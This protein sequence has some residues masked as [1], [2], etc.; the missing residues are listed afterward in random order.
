[1]SLSTP[2]LGYT[3]SKSRLID[4]GM[5][6]VKKWRNSKGLG[7]LML[8]DGPNIRKSELYQLSK[9]IGLEWFKFVLLVSSSQDDYVPFDSAR[10]EIGPRTIRDKLAGIYEEMAS[11][12]VGRMSATSLMRVDVNYVFDKKNFDYFIGRSAHIQMLDNKK[13]I[14]TLIFH[15]WDVFK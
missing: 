7:Q 8:H 15:F 1:M 6:F 9:A 5:W 10:I 4:A 11:N 3:P 14:K 13:L 12:L 2:H